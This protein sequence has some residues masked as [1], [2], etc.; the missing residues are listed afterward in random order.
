MT[1]ARQGAGAAGTGSRATGRQGA[2]AAGIET[3]ATGR[4]PARGRRRLALLAAGAAAA[5]ALG[6]APSAEGPRAGPGT[7]MLDQGDGWSPELRREW[8][9]LD[10]GSAL[11]PMAW[12]RALRV[13]GA[14][15]GPGFLD[16]GLARFGFLADLYDPDALP[17]GFTDA[18]L[19]GEEVLGMTCA[20]CHTREIEIDGRAYRADGGPALADH[21]GRVAVCSLPGVLPFSPPRYRVGRRY[22]WPARD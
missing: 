13:D 22:A 4:R 21:L 7:Y 12:A 2:G 17:V 11:I 18:V 1:E 15:E 10:Q 5:L 6:L 9:R 19:D 16:D 20:A 3:R 14:A 8:S